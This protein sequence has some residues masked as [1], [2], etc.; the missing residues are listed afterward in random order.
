MLENYKNFN[1]GAKEDRVDVR[2]FNFKDI[3]AGAPE[4]DWEIGYDIEENLGISFKI[5][6]QNGSSS[7]VG[8]AWSKYTEVL[9]YVEEDKLV[10]HSAKSIYEQIAL[11]GGGAYL[12]DGAKAVVDGGIALEK[13]VPSYLI[14][15][16]PPTE[17]FM[18]NNT[19]T[20]AIRDKMKIYKAKEYRSV[21]RGDFDLMALAI[22]ND[23]GMVG[24]LYGDNP[25][26]ANY[27]IKPPVSQNKWGHAVFFKAFGQDE[28]GKYFDFINSWGEQWGR[29]GVGRLYVD[30]YGIENM[31][32]FWTITDQANIKENIMIETIKLKDKPEIYAKSQTTNELYWIG[33]W[34]SYKVLLANGWIKPFE[35]VNNLDG[36]KITDQVFGFIK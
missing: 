17:E 1:P 3:V 28:N 19:L 5:E 9:N 14:D 29:E 24:G 20:D 10:N 21:S 7:C 33:G 32:S 30:I 8:Q 27:F 31:F 25:G 2:D 4:I 22:I 34:D 35:E 13:D 26:W 6:N 11:P 16:E 12:R 36:Y 15:N 23:F 18:R